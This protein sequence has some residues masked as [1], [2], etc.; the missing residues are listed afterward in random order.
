M[1]QPFAHEK[2][3]RLLRLKHASNGVHVMKMIELVLIL[4]VTGTIK[5]PGPLCFHIESEKSWVVSMVVY[6][7]VVVW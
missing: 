5:F 6:V 4:D 2:S 7:I 3:K 1:L